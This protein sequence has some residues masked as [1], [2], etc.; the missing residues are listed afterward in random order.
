MMAGHKYSE[1]PIEEAMC[2]FTLAEPIS[3]DATT[4]GKIFD[5]LKDRYPGMPAQQQLLQANLTPGVGAD[6]PTLAL[7][8]NERVVFIS[9][10][11][12]NRLSVAPTMIG[13]H[14]GRPYIGFEE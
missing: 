4:P 10:D 13:L 8:P 14:R 5:G 7:S 9:D 11:G 2:Q 12:I 1:P 6:S 3:W